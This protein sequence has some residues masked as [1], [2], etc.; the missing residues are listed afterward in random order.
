MVDSNLPIGD[1]HARNH[2]FSRTDFDAHRRYSSLATQQELGLR[3]K[4]W[5]RSSSSDP[6]HFDFDRPHLILFNERN[7][8]KIDN[9]FKAIFAS[10]MIVSGL[11][12]CDKP[13]T[14]ETAGK[15]IDQAVENVSSSASNAADKTNESV[16]KQGKI[17]GKAM[18]DT[19]ITAKTK[20]ALLNQPGMQSLKITVTTKDGVITLAGSA[21]SLENKNKAG[22]IAKHID[23][24]K[25]VKNM[26][27]ISK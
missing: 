22:D 13:G 2:Y 14:A 20:A 21:D 27:V 12:A 10:M 26:L 19:E 4:R 1:L 9:S 25:D 15:K 18:D 3:T 11:V 24:V 5:S 7:K 17:A 16:S 8:M 6:H 23:D